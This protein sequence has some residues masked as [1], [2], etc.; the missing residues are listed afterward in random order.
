MNIMK[1]DYYTVVLQSDQL[2]A[3]LKSLCDVL[4]VGKDVPP[5][6]TEEPTLQSFNDIVSEL[7]NPE[8]N[9]AEHMEVLKIGY[10]HF[11]ELFYER[12]LTWLDFVMMDSS[13]FQRVVAIK[14]LSLSGLVMI[15]MKKDPTG[16]GE[17]RIVSTNR[18]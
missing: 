14:A 18:Y 15:K 12:F 5:I 16:F 13:L 2:G 10:T 6:L 11:E 17:T 8:A 9:M 4:F 1:G 7:F 3:I